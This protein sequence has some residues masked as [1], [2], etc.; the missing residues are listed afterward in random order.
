MGLFLK[1][2]EKINT[3]N[4]NKK[5]IVPT[6]DKLFPSRLEANFFK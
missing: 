6:K 4:P 5:R 1:N 3:L 2:F